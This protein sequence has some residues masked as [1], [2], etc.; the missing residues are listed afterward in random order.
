MAAVTNIE[1]QYVAVTSTSNDR[2][3]ATTWWRLSGEV[4]RAD[5]VK[6]LNDAGLTD[7]A[8]TV[9]CPE[10][11]TALRRAVSE[12]RGKRRLIRPIRRGVWA[13]IEEEVDMT[14]DKL[15][16]WE[17]PVA[18]L[19][20]IGRAQ[21]DNATPEEAELVTKQ[22]AHHL[23]VLTTEDVSAWL[24]HR[25][26]AA[27]A[28]AMRGGGGVYYVPPAQ[29]PLWR[30]IKNALASCAG[31]HRIHTLP[32]MEITS[33]GAEAILDALST[34]VETACARIHKQCE[35]GLGVRALEYRT[36]FG[37]GL[38]NKVTEYESLMG[39]RLDR[40][41]E[42]LGTLEVDVAQARMAAEAEVDDKA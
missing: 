40:M 32:T 26:Q 14:K 13:V 38:L 23:Q 33:D 28:V 37:Q 34:E 1:N 25:V 31:G 8:D 42:L 36:T 19:D 10:P 30:A 2:A 16:H 41:R 3:G 39:T 6:A 22:Y 27:S 11:E 7:L 29:M 20:K 4:L 35:E 15:K 21:L 12:L 9:P 18:R 5:L 17:G 24:S